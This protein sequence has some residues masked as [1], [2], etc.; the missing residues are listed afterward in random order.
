[1]ENSSENPT[2]RVPVVEL[3][4]KLVADLTNYAQRP[5]QIVLCG[6]GIAEQKFGDTS[7]KAIKIRMN[8]EALIGVR[9]LDQATT[10]WRGIGFYRLLN[11][12]NDV[13]P[14]LESTK[15]S[16]VSALF[17]VLN[18]EHNQ[19]RAAAGDKELDALLQTLCAHRYRRK[20]MTSPLFYESESKAVGYENHTEYRRRFED[21]A[22]FLRRHLPPS[23]D[24][25]SA[26]VEALSLVPENLKDLSKD[27]VLHLTASVHA[28][29]IKG[30]SVPK[31]A[32]SLTK[33]SKPEV[34][35]AKDEPEIE[36]FDEPEAEVAEELADIVS[37]ADKRWWQLLFKNKVSY[38]ILGS[39]VLG[40]LIFLLKAGV[41]FWM[42][43]AGLSVVTVLMVAVA[44][45]AGLFNRE[46][47]PDGSSSWWAAIVRFFS[48]KWLPFRFHWPWRSGEGFRWPFSFNWNLDIFSWPG[49]VWRGFINHVV[50]P[51]RD[52]ILACSR[53][54][55]R[56]VRE[57]SFAITNFLEDL[58][59]SKASRYIFGGIGRGF[60][61]LTAWLKRS[62]VLLWRHST[63]RL[64]VLA[65]PIAVLI[66][67]VIGMVMLGSDLVLWQ[68][69]VVG[70]IWL[71]VLALGYFYLPQIK[72]WVIADVYAVH[73]NAESNAA[74]R[75]PVDKT[76]TTFSKI[77]E[78]EPV[79]ANAQFLAAVIEK[80]VVAAE[81]LK[82][83]LRRCGYVTASRDNM[84]EGYDLVDDIEMAEYTG[85][86]QI[87]VDE[88]QKLR[89]S[90]HIDVLVDCSS[91]QEEATANLRK[92]EKFLRSKAFA[93]AIEEAIRGRRGVS[94]R[95]WGYD[96]KAIYDCG[97]AGDNRIS[98]LALSGG[99]NNDAAALFHVTQNV[100]GKSKRV[101]VLI[102][103]AQPADC[104]WGAL[105]QLGFNLLNEGVT[106][107][108]VLTEDC[109]D[110][111]LKWHVVDIYSQSLSKASSFLGRILEAQLVR[112]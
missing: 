11:E 51:V 3:T 93:L 84:T 70:V 16:G 41:D 53:G 87:F 63:F 38:V 108:Q 110:P 89:T 91:S 25:D 52:F 44:G 79:D 76:T 62:L 29:L 81:P 18:D 2:L 10:L 111:A 19:R 43:V 66:A 60:T 77:E 31:D 58:V 82:E 49:K 54:F 8:P 23:A 88:I 35:P 98:G 47:K 78:V 26:V 99:G 104:S 90:L 32:V 27:E 72:A 105:H 95:L 103:D 34:T 73:Q 68:I 22:Y 64:F 109:D 13:A 96:D 74:I 14:Q 94:G 5:V 83:S 24:I 112:K 102:S 92:G 42:A 40:W 61:E 20:N 71:V 1:M 4:Q 86:T 7:S 57:I 80:A 30:L 101:V 28:I 65:L 9:K 75:L 15:T 67:V 37:P 6:G 39:F 100:T 107:V 12:L 17:G 85:D 33:E 56:T 97:A 36:F 48:F 45:F 69:V 21:F 46:K 55:V 106:V 50:L 59:K